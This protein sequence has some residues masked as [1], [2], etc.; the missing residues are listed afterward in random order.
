M[1][2][3]YEAYLR[4]V[5]PKYKY[6]DLAKR[7]ILSALQS[8]TDLRPQLSTH[9]FNDGNARE[10][11]CLDGTIPVMYKGK[12]YNIPVCLWL[13]DTHPYN[14][15]MVFVKPTA[16]MQIKPGKHVDANGRIYLPYLHEWKHPQSDLAGLIQILVCIFGEEP[17]VFAKSQS[18]ASQPPYPTGA[19][20]TPYPT[21]GSTMP[22]PNNYPPAAG[23]GGY[24][25]PAPYGG[26]P[27]YPPYPGGY[28]PATGQPSQPP[29]S[30]PPYQNYPHGCVPFTQTS[31]QYPQQQTGNYVHIITLMINDS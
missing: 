23:P 27:Q 30:Q 31:Q 19:A 26:P 9:V 2:S 8:F 10:L 28:P 17:P 24:R 13:L 14:P 5:L 20:F 29:A 18:T 7:E 15:P 3:Q 1:T 6:P 11:L 12:T 4:S 21:T 25:A 16:F 22:Q